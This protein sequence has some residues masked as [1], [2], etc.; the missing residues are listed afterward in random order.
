M[1]PRFFPPPALSLRSQKHLAPY[2]FGSDDVLGLVFGKQQLPPKEQ[3]S[4]EVTDE[5]GVED[6]GGKAEKLADGD[7]VADKKND[8]AGSKTD[9]GDGAPEETGGPKVEVEQESGQGGD[10]AR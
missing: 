6:G 7:E 1:P 5:G 10:K 9:R 3:P 4:L 2:G 8:A